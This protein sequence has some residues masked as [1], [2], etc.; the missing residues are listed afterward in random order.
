[1]ETL[2]GQKTEGTTA[3]AIVRKAAGFRFECTRTGV[4]EELELKL[5]EAYTGKYSLAVFTDG[6]ESKQPGTAVAGTNEKESEVTAQTVLK[7]TG[8]SVSVEKGVFYW[9]CLDVIGVGAS[10]KVKRETTGHSKSSVSE[11]P[12]APPTVASITKWKQE[13]TGPIYIAGIGTESSV[14]QTSPKVVLELEVKAVAVGGGGVINTAPK[15]AMQLEAFAEVQSPGNPSE[16][17]TNLYYGPSVDEKAEKE[18]QAVKATEHNCRY[19]DAWG[20][21]SAGAATIVTI[22]GGGLGPG[23][24]N[25]VEAVPK[26]LNEHGYCVF[27]V[28]Y[29]YS[30]TTVGALGEGTAETARTLSDVEEAITY[31]KGNAEAHNGNPNNIFVLGGSAGGLLG[32][33]AAIKMNSTETK[34]KGVITFSGY[35]DLKAFFEEMESGKYHEPGGGHAG[36]SAND[37]IQHTQWGFQQ[38]L[39]YTNSS[40]EGTGPP[41]VTFATKTSAAGDRTVQKNKSPN[42]LTIARPSRWFTLFYAED[43]IPAVQQSAYKT[44]LETEK[45][46]QVKAH[47]QGGAGHGWTMFANNL[48]VRTEVFEFIEAA[49]AAPIVEMALEAKA[50]FTGVIPGGGGTSRSPFLEVATAGKHS[51]IRTRT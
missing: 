44:H 3:V 2:I 16:K 42:L 25:E 7:T 9:L 41:V 38:E 32:A 29:R 28:D 47:E 48:S 46:A 30:S 36:G 6:T 5:S 14:I 27:S 20:A 24:R 18:V 49:Q 33:V 21:P 12:A 22:H 39:D 4:I 35:F 31:A 11:E 43:L 19:L 17:E 51:K 50:T 23:S 45:Q 34:V 26:K 40:G 15:V 1:M 13:T 8:L 37:L 10:M